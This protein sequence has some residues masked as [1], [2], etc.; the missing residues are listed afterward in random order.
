MP[1]FT[2]RPTKEHK[3]LA[4]GLLE[5]KGLSYLSKLVEKDNENDFLRTVK[6]YALRVNE[7]SRTPK[8]KLVKEYR[9]KLTP[10]PS[11]RLPVVSAFNKKGAISV[12]P[13]G[14]II[15]LLYDYLKEEKIDGYLFLVSGGAKEAIG[16]KSELKSRIGRSENFE[17]DDF[18]PK[19]GPPK[20]DGDFILVVNKVRIIEERI[21]TELRE[22]SKNNP[23]EIKTI[24]SSS[25]PFKRIEIG[26]V[27]NKQVPQDEFWADYWQSHG[28]IVAPKFAGNHSFN[29]S[30]I[31]SLTSDASSSPYI[32][33]IPTK[34]SGGFVGVRIDFFPNSK[35][36]KEVNYSKNPFNLCSLKPTVINWPQIMFPFT[37]SPAEALA[38]LIHLLRNVTWD[39]QLPLISSLPNSQLESILSKRFRSRTQK[40]KAISLNTSLYFAKMIIYPIASNVNL[41]AENPISMRQSTERLLK[42]ILPMLNGNPY[43]GLIYLLAAEENP[44]D[45][46]VYGTGFIDP[47]GFFPELYN[48]LHQ[49]DRLERLIKLMAETEEGP[50]MK[51]WPAFL[52]FIYRETNFDLKKTARF[53]NPNFCSMEV[54]P[55][56]VEDFISPYLE[57]SPLSP[58]LIS[59]IP[60]AST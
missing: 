3:T 43:L 35:L 34:T 6:E 15:K 52:N 25:R 38:V 48:F 49:G 44:T 29:F 42:S 58:E 36:Y 14:K 2:A 47:K 21:V 39:D 46:P 12:T 19:S 20:M 28:H 53:L 40:I 32:L 17:L 18:N 27:F 54:Y 4:K 56:L 8:P 9:V 55:T 1:T 31:Q 5:E 41:I 10:I 37:S 22:R 51:G 50:T 11:S 45:A 33:I 59:S 30:L 24:S 57:A 26:T 23:L 13:L 7:N 16:S 60:L